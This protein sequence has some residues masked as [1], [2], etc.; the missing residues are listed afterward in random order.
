MDEAGSRS[1]TLGVQSEFAD[2][3]AKIEDERMA[4]PKNYLYTPAHHARARKKDRSFELRFHWCARTPIGEI[5]L[6]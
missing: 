1:S 2:L 6:R 3:G 4:S 5:L